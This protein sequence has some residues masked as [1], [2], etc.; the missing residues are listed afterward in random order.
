MKKEL[1]KTIVVF[2]QK[3]KVKM[4]V[5]EGLAGTCDREKRIITINPDQSEEEKIQT[6]L[7]EI[8]HAVFSRVG[9]IQAIPLEL[10]EI[11]V[12]SIATA[13]SENFTLS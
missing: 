7:H 13:I 11:V 2:G 10:E 3:Y 9:L 12:E 5:I 6:L 1:P 8:G 4:E